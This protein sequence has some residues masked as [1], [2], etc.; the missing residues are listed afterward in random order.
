MNQLH[1][2]LSNKCCLFTPS[3]R[4]PGG[5]GSGSI[6][7]TRG[8]GGGLKIRNCM[9][10]DLIFLIFHSCNDNAKLI[11]V[12]PSLFKLSNYVLFLCYTGGGFLCSGYGPLHTH[13]Y[14][15]THARTRARTHTH[16]HRSERE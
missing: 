14:T 5:M 9:A 3:F 11:H 8:N 1:G 16:S 10:S 6:V 15:N 7:V 2:L 12:L 13:T 4:Q